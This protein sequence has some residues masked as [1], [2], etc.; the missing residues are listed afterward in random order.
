MRDPAVAGSTERGRRR[1][2]RSRRLVALAAAVLMTGCA[3]VPTDGPVR[4][5]PEGADGISSVRIEARAPEDGATPAQIAQGFLD[6][7]SSSDV[8]FSLAKQFLT[9]SAEQAWQLSPITIYDAPEIEVSGG[10]AVRLDAQR[11]ADID[12]DGQYTAATPGTVLEVELPMVQQAGEWRISVPPPGVLITTFDRDNDYSPYVT[13]YPST[14]T[15]ILVPDL[16]WL[17]GRTAQ[18][19]TVLAQA[20]VDGQT[21]RLGDSVTNAFPEGTSVD[22]V[23]IASGGVATVDLSGPLTTA[24]PA[25]LQTM[26]AQL[27]YTLGRLPTLLGGVVLTADGEPLAIPGAPGV[28]RPSDFANRDPLLGFRNPSAYALMSDRLVALNAEGII[29][30]TEGPLGETAGGATQ[31]AVDLNESLAAVVSA[32]GRSVT[33]QSITGEIEPPPQNFTGIDVARPSWDRFGN[34]WVVDRTPRGSVVY[35]IAPDGTGRDLPIAAPALSTGRVLAFRVAPDGARIAAA[36]EKDGTTRLLFLRVVRGE[37]V[38]LSGVADPAAL[39]G[40]ASVGD[41]AWVG[42]T[43]VAVVVTAPERAAQP[44]VVPVDGSA[45]IPEVETGVTSVAG[46]PQQTLFAVTE[47]GSIRRR[48]S[49]ITW[50]T[51]GPG[52]AVTYPG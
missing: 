43:S 13:F 38:I 33:T 37:R 35:T 9:D 11:V 16:V 1:I 20:L 30:A 44:A 26:A 51:V 36:V 17:P 29:A 5:G 21:T 6:A 25:A 14:V 3:Q 2:G 48:V 40:L 23:S 27:A 50:D 15:N 19:A 31:V 49:A 47:D 22:T 8:G 41:L 4:P 32:D 7:M 39:P 52:T 24:D 45:V 18:V 42:D 34:L 12:V 10:G 46:Y 28:L